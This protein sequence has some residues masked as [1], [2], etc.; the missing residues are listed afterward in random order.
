MSVMNESSTVKPSFSNSSKKYSDKYFPVA[1]SNSLN[2]AVLGSSSF[3][4]LN[5]REK[6]GIS[7]E[8]DPNMV[9]SSVFVDTGSKGAGENVG[10]GSLV[11]ESGGRVDGS[12]F[13]PP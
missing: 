5:A 3:K 8:N 2:S 11:G 10:A 1:S 6:I 4:S 13:D 9:G 7:T 12:S